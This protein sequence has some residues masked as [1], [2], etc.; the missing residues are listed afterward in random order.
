[1]KKDFININSIDLDRGL[2]AFYKLDGN[3]KDD[4]AYGNNGIVY[5]AVPDKDRFGRDNCSYRFNGVDNY[6]LIPESINLEMSHNDFSIAAWVNPSAVAIGRIFSKGS[7]WD[8]VSGYLFRASVTGTLF[9]SAIQVIN[10]ASYEAVSLESHYRLS[11]N[12]WSFIVVTVNRSSIANIYI[13]AR[14]DNQQSINAGKYD[15][16]SGIDATIGCAHFKDEFHE[17]FNHS[18]LLLPGVDSSD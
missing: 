7:W 13:N 1:M 6:V 12:Q 18:F 3:A 17:F 14:L 10:S 15:L 16:Y 2:V 8:E 4:S 9:V 5:G 11:I